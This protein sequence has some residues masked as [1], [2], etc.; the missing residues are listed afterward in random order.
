MKKTVFIFCLFIPLL[1]TA[2]KRQSTEEFILEVLARQKNPM[3]N[4]PYNRDRFLP[5]ESEIK[6]ME[7]DANHPVNGKSI[8]PIVFVRANDTTY[9][10]EGFV[11]G[12]G[13]PME[14]FISTKKRRF[15]SMGDDYFLEKQ[16]SHL[17]R[18]PQLGRFLYNFSRRRPY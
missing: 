10:R 4:I 2:Q 13:A 6:K 12:N 9:R 3:A 11:D 7:M 1:A 8:G 14:S 5:S 17:N 18:Y 16:K 15:S